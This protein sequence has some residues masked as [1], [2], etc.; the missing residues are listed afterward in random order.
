MQKREQYL[1]RRRFLLGSSAAVAGSLLIP[2]RASGMVGRRRLTSHGLSGSASPAPPVPTPITGATVNPSVYQMTNWVDAA[3]TFD[4]YVGY[5]LATTIQKIYMLEG[6]YYTDPLPSRM[7]QLA[8]VGCQFIVCVY[9]SRTTD[10]S[11][12]LS[13]FLQ[14]LNSNGIVYQAALDNEWNTKDKFTPQTYLAYWSHYA[15]VVQA[16]GVPLALMVCASSNRSEFAKI[17]P[18]FPTDPLPDVYW[19]DYYATGYRWNVRLARSG[20]LLQQAEN[21][22]VPAG[23]G[24]FGW[25][26]DGNVTMQQWN[27][28]CYYLRRLAPRLP[29]GCLYWGA[30]G[31]DAVTSAQDPKIPGIRR[32][33]SAFQ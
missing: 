19:I 18:G 13:D 27:E 33:I 17:E 25:A 12:Q 3:N 4:S 8:S 1:S 15:P 16:A 30:H 29:L 28:Y 11:S 2:G 23:L 6:Q 9:P 26:A 22:G 7:R 5:P 32:V 21:Y 24:E 31:I 14:L 10:E 20:G